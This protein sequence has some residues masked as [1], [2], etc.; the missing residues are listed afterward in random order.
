MLLKS[1]TI[2]NSKKLI[3]V[4]T[5]A[6][7]KIVVVGDPISQAK[8]FEAQAADELILLNI[9]S[10]NVSHEL[11]FN[12]LNRISEEIFMP[13]TIGGGIDSIELIRLYLK[14]GADKV[15]VNTFGFT[16]TEFIRKA[17]SLFGSQCIVCSIDYKIHGNEAYVYINQGKTKTDKK[18]I[19][20]VKECEILGVGELLITNI[21]H[22]GSNKGLDLYWLDKICKT[23][24]IPVIASGGCS[25]ASHF[26]EGFQRGAEAISAGS[27]FCF[28][29]QNQFQLRSQ[30]SNCSIPVRLIK[31]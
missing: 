10:S 9:D 6:F 12:I 25:L 21:D 24:K 31:C 15:S 3:L 26:I 28:R 18:V 5:I 7:D 16:N 13:I 1:I 8:I 11:M 30:I 17:S 19:D 23:V 4:T 2:G 14:N 29:D 22:D 20:W 27:F